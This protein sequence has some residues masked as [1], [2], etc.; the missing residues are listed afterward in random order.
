[1]LVP[2]LTVYFI[3]RHFEYSCDREAIE[4]TNDPDAG[5]HALANLYRMTGSPVTCIRIVELF[6]THPSLINRLEAIARA[7]EMPINRATAVL[8]EEGL[9]SH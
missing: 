7:G 6:M 2:L 4:F 8:V 1:M 9:Q 5:L 3:S